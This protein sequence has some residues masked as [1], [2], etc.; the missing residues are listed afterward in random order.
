MRLELPDI[1]IAD[2]TGIGAWVNSDA[3]G[4]KSLDIESRLQ[5]IGHISATRIAHNGN[6]ID[7]Y[8]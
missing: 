4:T 5:Q 3:I 6:L 8:T 2:V 1:A 7:I